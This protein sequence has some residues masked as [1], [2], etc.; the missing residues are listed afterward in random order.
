[1]ESMSHPSA[2]LVRDLSLC[3]S[4]WSPFPGL[5][6]AEAEGVPYQESLFK[7]TIS[8][9]RLGPLD[10]SRS[11][12]HTRRSLDREW[13]RAGRAHRCR[14]P[15]RK[16]CRRDLLNGPVPQRPAGVCRCPRAERKRHRW[17]R[18]HG[19]PGDAFLTVARVMVGQSYRP[20]CHP[21]GSPSGGTTGRPLEVMVRVTMRSAGR[22]EP[23]LRCGRRTAC[24]I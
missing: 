11:D 19:S 6:V 13:R 18:S 21:T 12:V 15:R 22:C 17:H 1:M 9:L 24:A 5:T 8:G 2:K 10:C 3:Y 20:C 23:R 16:L 7:T 4:L 14:I